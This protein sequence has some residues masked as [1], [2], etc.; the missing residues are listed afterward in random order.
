MTESAQAPSLGR[1]TGVRRR[2]LQKTAGEIHALKRPNFLIIQ[3]DQHNPKIAGYAGD[4]LARTQALDALAE[5]ST[6]FD[7]AYCQ[8]PLC[9]PSRLSML[10]GRYVGA[11]KAWNNTC[12]LGPEHLTFAE[13]LGNNGYTTALV[14][15]MHLAGPRWM[16]GFQHR[17]YGDLCVDRFCFHQPDPVETWDGRWC[18]HAVGRFP[19]AGE[20]EIPESL[21]ADANVTRESLAFLL[22]HADTAPDRPWLLVAG[23]SRPHFPLTAPGRY[24][25]RAAREV[26]G[27]PPK[28]AGY[29]DCLHPHDRYIVEDFHLLEFPEEDHIR[30]LAAYYACVDYVDDC[31]GELL[32]SLQKAGL[33]ENTYVI[34]L[35]DH[36]D[37]CAEKG[38]W[39]KRTYYDASARVP[40]MICG[41]DIPA[42]V[43]IPLPV[44]LTDLF[45]TLCELAGAPVPDALDGVSLIPLLGGDPA[46]CSRRFA[47]SELLTPLKQ[48]AFRMARDERWKYVEFPE[49]PPR[50]FDMRSDPEETVDLL[51]CSPPP[52]DCPLADLEAA[53]RQGL[54]WDDIARLQEE[55][56]SS[57]PPRIRHPGRGPVQY[58]FRGERVDGDAFLYPGLAEAGEED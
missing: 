17:P 3:T 43:R 51:E 54:S 10:T 49:A 8:S 38:L 25:R 23:Y 30:A 31:I 6:I 58:L 14:G 15:K 21:L 50:L 56:L 40:L 37:M 45:P 44:E 19:W 1:K 52:P 20:T 33:L 11:L 28:P 35:S 41:P 39:C 12:E 53:A 48:T 26:T 29:P 7:A 16:G 47:R 24:F 9:V 22:E 5:R 27:L 46:A 57:R 34:Y 13:H 55:D 2:N 42:G 36:G 18:N 32:D 4:P